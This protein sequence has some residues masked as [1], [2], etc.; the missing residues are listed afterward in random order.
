M[1]L[2]FFRPLYGVP[3]SSDLGLFFFPL[4]KCENAAS[5]KIFRNCVLNYSW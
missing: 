2:Q 5:F 4:E 3:Q 1:H